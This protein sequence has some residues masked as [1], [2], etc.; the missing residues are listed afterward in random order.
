MKEDA[1]RLS[2]HLKNWHQGKDY[3][4][5]IREIYGKHNSLFHIFKNVI[6]KLSLKNVQTYAYN[7]VHS[8]RK[9]G[10]PIGSDKGGYYYCESR[11]EAIEYYRKIRSRH[12]SGLKNARIFL[13]AVN[14]TFPPIQEELKL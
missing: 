8:L 9:A 2:E 7:C 11:K 10:E 5:T 12:L 4:I 6:G 1:Q 14:K 3:A 13:R